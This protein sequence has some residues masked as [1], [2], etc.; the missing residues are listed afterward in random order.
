MDVYHET[1][2]VFL[3]MKNELKRI[4]RREQTKAVLQV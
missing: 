2:D 3:N 4:S 1:A